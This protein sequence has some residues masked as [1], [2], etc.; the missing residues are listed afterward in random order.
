MMDKKGM[1]A[2]DTAP[3]YLIFGIVIT[4]LF[5]LFMWIVSTHAYAKIKIPRGVE[6]AGVETR[7]ANSCFGYRDR[8]GTTHSVII[9]FAL[10][11]DMVLEECYN[12]DSE[13]KPAYKLRLKV[14]GQ[15][16]I[17]T[18]PEVKTKNWED[19]IG[20]D[21]RTKKRALVYYNEEVNRGEIGKEVQWRKYRLR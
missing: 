15:S 1:Y 4:V 9:D 14:F 3:F 16:S 5:M 12:T 8:S 18:I 21:R 13:N 20:M 17:S 2:A 11:D 19:S 6:E 7:F 10:F